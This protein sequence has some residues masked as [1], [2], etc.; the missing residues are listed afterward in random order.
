MPLLIPLPLTYTAKMNSSNDNSSIS[1]NDSIRILVVDD[2]PELLKHLIERL[3]YEPGIEVA[4]Q[5]VNYSEAVSIAN[6]ANPNLILI[7][8]VMRGENGNILLHKLMS[9]LPSA[10]LI[11][12][13]A[14]V[15]ISMKLELSK[16]GV[17][18]ILEKGI[19]FSELVAII[20]AETISC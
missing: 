20:R 14:I 19:E 2:H 17:G 5:A 8:P 1:S 15:D 13:T 18:K 7:D 4:G 10:R 6:S 3:K 11:V 16:L 12:L 9:I